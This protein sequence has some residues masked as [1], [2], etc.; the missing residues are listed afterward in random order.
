M[1]DY[2]LRLS[3]KGRSG[4]TRIQYNDLANISRASEN[5]TDR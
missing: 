4:I 3:E 1:D 5:N 2:L